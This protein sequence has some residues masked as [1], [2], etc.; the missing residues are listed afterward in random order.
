M[1]GPWIP[2]NW[3]GEILFTMAANPIHTFQ[4]L[5]KNPEDLSKWQKFFPANL[6]LG[7]SVT[8]QEDIKK[9]DYLRMVEP[10]IRFISFEPL[11]GPIDAVLERIHW[12]IIGAQTRPNRI[13]EKEWVQRLID[14]ARKLSIPVFLKDNLRWPEKI[15][16]FPRPYGKEHS[17]ASNL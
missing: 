16:E 7:V 10:A 9:I 6:W 8:K 1:F 2:D 13:P 14:R 12:I 17:N 11:L 4:V 15:Q 5:T 3:I